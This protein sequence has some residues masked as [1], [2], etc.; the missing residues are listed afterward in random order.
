MGAPALDRVQ[1][2]PQ[3][4]SVAVPR[5]RRQPARRGRSADRKLFAEDVGWAWGQFPAL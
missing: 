1:G 5:H 3:E 2:T 4:S